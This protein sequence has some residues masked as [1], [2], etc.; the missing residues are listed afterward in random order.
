[1]TKPKNDFQPLTD[2]YLAYLV[3][4]WRADESGCWHALARNVQ[5]EEE[6][7][8]ATIEQCITFLNEAHFNKSTRPQCCTDWQSV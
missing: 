3:R 4:F 5:T 2:H 7:R 1:M 6:H 8:F